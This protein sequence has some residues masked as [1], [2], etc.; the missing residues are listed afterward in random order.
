MTHV[1]TSLTVSKPSEPRFR[2]LEDVGSS[3][4]A[5]LIS[6]GSLL[7]HT[8]FSHLAFSHVNFARCVSSSS[9]FSGLSGRHRAPDTRSGDL[10]RFPV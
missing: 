2:S 10:R 9:S 5:E 6:S 3:S 1:P 7:S 4:S 8:L